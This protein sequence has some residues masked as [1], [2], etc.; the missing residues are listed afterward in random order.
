MKRIA[1]LLAVVVLMVGMLAM[2]VALAFAAQP[3][4]TCAK[5]G[6]QPAY[7]VPP[8]YAHVVRRATS[9]TDTFARRRP[10]RRRG[11]PAAVDSRLRGN[12]GRGPDNY[13]PDRGQPWQ[14]FRPRQEVLRGPRR[15]FRRGLWKG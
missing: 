11:V 3:S 10:D 4:Y 15:R 6:E 2:S 8:K 1:V 13:P 14:P 12:G 5:E 9:G 7:Y